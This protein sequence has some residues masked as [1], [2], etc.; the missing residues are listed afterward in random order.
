MHDINLH[1]PKCFTN[2]LGIWAVE[3]TAGRAMLDA[4]QTGLLC[5]DAENLDAPAQ[6]QTFNGVR[7]ISIN[8][9]MQKG[10]SKFGGTST[11]DVRR[12]I[13]KANRDESVNGIML[14]IDS[15]G[16]HASGNQAL[17]DDIASSTKPIRA[18]VD[19]L[20]ASAALWAAAGAEHISVDKTGI[21]GSIGTFAV[22]QDVTGALE[23][24]GIELH[25]V[26]TGPLK[27]AGSD[28]KVTP[29][30]LAEVQKRVD[31]VNEF[32]L[33]SLAEG[34]SMSRSDIDA[35]ATGQVFSAT[36]ALANGLIDAISDF[37]T[38]LV[39]FADAVT[40]KSRGNAAKARVSI[41]K[42]RLNH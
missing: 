34:R 26:S 35:L 37:D 22:L 31:D 9:T 18:H 16:G 7:V 17:F 21:V 3:P 19:D 2:H 42:R 27:G 6:T 39:E 1:N 8:G 4:I 36:E 29:E 12:E 38:A 23:A 25:L 33:Q 24:E 28:G 41:A 32:F 13:M 5:A 40:P 10:R 30:L 15:P 11:Q 20:A 14:M